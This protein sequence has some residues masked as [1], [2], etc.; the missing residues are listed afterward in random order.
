ML[1]KLATFLLQPV[2]QPHLYEQVLHIQLH[3]A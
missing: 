3:V 2:S 1:H